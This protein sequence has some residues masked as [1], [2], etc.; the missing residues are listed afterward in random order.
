MAH[1]VE[2]SENFEKEICADDQFKG[3][4]ELR[5]DLSAHLDAV[6]CDYTMP[7]DYLGRTDAFSYPHKAVCAGLEKIHV[8]DESCPKYTPALSRRWERTN[9][10]RDRTSDTYFVYSRNFWDEKHCK[11]FAVLNPAHINGDVNK[12]GLKFLG[13]IIDNAEEFVDEL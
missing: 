6:D 1:K 11:F 9:R 12:T 2:F 3:I 8:L 10:F 13:P 4:E 7:I 5:S